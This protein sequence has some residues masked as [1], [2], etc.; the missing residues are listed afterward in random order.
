[1]RISRVAWVAAA[2]LVAAW[3]HGDD[4]APLMKPDGKGVSLGG[5]LS[6]LMGAAFECEPQEAEAWSGW[7]CSMETVTVSIEGGAD[8]VWALAL[9]SPDLSKAGADRVDEAVAMLYGTLLVFGQVSDDQDA[10]IDIGV[11]AKAANGGV[12]VLPL[13]GGTF[14]AMQDREHDSVTVIFKES[15]IIADPRVTALSLMA[16]MWHP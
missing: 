12:Y 13:G 16:S 1:M 8:G 14:A 10:P 9:Q 4:R 5:V 2:V 3:A 6:E 11:G 7:Q 15:S